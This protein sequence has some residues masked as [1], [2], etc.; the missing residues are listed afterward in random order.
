MAILCY[1]YILY[2]NILVVE[3]HCAKLRLYFC[4]DVIK[5]KNV[6]IEFKNA[7]FKKNYFS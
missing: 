1:T 7:D 6:V 5:I 2:V 3:N 4:F